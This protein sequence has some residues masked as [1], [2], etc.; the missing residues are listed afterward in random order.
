MLLYW[1]SCGPISRTNLPLWMYVRKA[2]HS[3]DSKS[4]SGVRF[5]IPSGFASG[6]PSG[7]TSG[8]PET[9]LSARESIASRN[10][11]SGEVK[12]QSGNIGLSVHGNIGLSVHG[13]RTRRSSTGMDMSAQDPLDK[14]PWTDGYIQTKLLVLGQDR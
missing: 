3:M 1:I 13:N 9:N 7:F 11:R 6:I 5:G 4:A 8:N 2:L 14:V 10:E 12:P